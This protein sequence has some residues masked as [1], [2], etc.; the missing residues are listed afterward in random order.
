MNMLLL[1]YDD[2]IALIMSLLVTSLLL[3][4]VIRYANQLNMQDTPDARKVHIHTMPRTGGLAMLSGLIVSFLVVG[5]ASRCVEAIVLGVGVIAVTGIIDD[6][7]GIKSWQKFI[8]E[9]L[10]AIVFIAWS[11]ISLHSLGDLLGVGVIVTGS[12]GPLITVVG[13]VGVI[14]AL[15]LSDGLDGLAGGLGF[16]ACLFMVFFGFSSHSF[17]CLPVL[18]VLMGALLAFLVYNAH[19]AKVFMGDT[20]SLM[21]G[22][23]LATTAV[24]FAGTPDSSIQPVSMA[25]ILAL[26][27]LDTVYVMSRR[28]CQGCSPFSPDKTH[29]HH[30]LLALGIPHGAVVSIL[31]VVMTLFGVL[32]VVMREQPEYVQFACGVLLALAVFAGV[33]LLEHRH[34]CWREAVGGEVLPEAAIYKK[35][36]ALSGQSIPLITWM[37]PLVLFACAWTLDVSDDYAVLA[38]GVLILTLVM[39]PWTE[40]TDRL[41]VAHGLIFLSV[42][43]IM[44]VFA[45][46]G[47]TRTQMIYAAFSAFM[48]VWVLLKLLFRRQGRDFFTSGFE[49]LVLLIVVSGFLFIHSSH[50]LSAQETTIVQL[51]LIESVPVLMAIKIVL[52]RQ[53][54]RNIHLMLGLS[55]VLV[56]FLIH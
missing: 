21:L 43:F 4:F 36:T 13:I 6:M 37:I 53:P 12:F 23:I 17:D 19:P 30:R 44:V 1:R 2:M 50:A 25:L 20:G 18:F 46:E 31:Y 48:A 40:H 52:R 38:V 24:A 3:P 26:P 5:P 51:T 8:G 33:A 35:I 27:I 47:N 42:I 32:A 15:N 39:Y 55:L 28:I 54:H 22:Y 16:I 7:F 49:V 9:I 45:F 34:Y 11:G 14:N 10:A 29:L 41:H 56:F